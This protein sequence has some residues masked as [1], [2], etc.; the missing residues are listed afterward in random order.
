MILEFS[1][2][3]F[4]SIKNRQ[5]LSF[6]ADDDAHLDNYYV[7]EKG[8]YRILKLI[9]ILGANASGKSNI[10]GGLNFLRNIV[11]HP[12][13]SKDSH[14]DY[15]P[16]LLSGIES[17]KDSEIDL[18]FFCGDYR[19][20]YHLIFNR[21][22]ITHETLLS[23]KSGEENI[24][25]V[26]E[27]FTEVDKDHSVIKW[28]EKYSNADPEGA[29]KPALL[30]NRTVFATYQLS[31]VDIPWMK[32]ILDWFKDY[33]LPNIHPHEQ[34]LKR[35]IDSHLHNHKID[36]T[37]LV[38]ELKKADVGIVDLNLEVKKKPIPKEIV[39]MLLKDDDAPESLKAKISSD[40]TSTDLDLTLVHEGENGYVP[41]DFD[42]ESE[43][44]Q[45]Y[46]EL[47]GILLLL[48]NDNHFLAVDELD[49]RLHPDLYDHFIVSFLSNSKESQL[50]FSTH[51][52][53][54]LYDTDKYRDDSV[55]F[56]EK[57]KGGATE[58][59]SL[60]DFDNRERSDIK[61]R[62]FA[63]KAGRFGAVPML[64]ETSIEKR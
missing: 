5:T 33:M 23:Q 35:Y 58:L 21:K 17:E 29:L 30:H 13:N 62:Y 38:H 11:L 55:W 54:F 7:I 44:T 42:N 3:N 2:S 47:A 56:T 25:I 36:K 4:R 63:Y 1:L 41:L 12:A 49:Y 48:V 15:T 27:R 32:E 59:Y 60:A 28:G 20:E 61:N 45:R 19:Y 14:L 40:P 51:N 18:N 31:N 10:L 53:E 34:N 6:I 46:Y 57:L 24:E 64:G 39:E 37:S 9:S 26:F 50:V 22:N 52:R 8:G 43:G 16:F